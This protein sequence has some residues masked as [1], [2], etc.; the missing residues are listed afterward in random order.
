MSIKS[1]LTSLSGAIFL[2][3]S[4][5]AFALPFSIVPLDELPTTVIE[6]GTT[7]AQYIVTNTTK[8]AR[9]ENFVQFFP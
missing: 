4:A 9:E 5:N 6:G 8:I 7:I 1:V 2:A 3:I